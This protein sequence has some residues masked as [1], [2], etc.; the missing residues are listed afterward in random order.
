MNIK[1]MVLVGLLLVTGL[2]LLE[3]NEVFAGIVNSPHDIILWL[4]SNTLEKAG[5]CAYCHVPHSAKGERLFPDQTAPEKAEFGAVAALC[6]KCHRNVDY[7]GLPA[8]VVNSQIFLTLNPATRGSTVS[9]STMDSHPT[10]GTDTTQPKTLQNTNLAN[11]RAMDWPWTATWSSYDGIAPKA[12]TVKDIECSTCHNPHNW[13][14]NA[15]DT[16]SCGPAQ[17]KFLRAPVYNK[18][19]P[20]GQKN[21]CSICHPG[22]ESDSSSNSLGTHPVSAGPAGSALYAS[23]SEW[24][25]VYSS[26]LYKDVTRM[27]KPFRDS[28][29]V[30]TGGATREG[31]AI[32]DSAVVQGYLG[33]RLYDAGDGKGPDKIIC[34][35][36]HAPHGAAH[37]DDDVYGP[38]ANHGNDTTKLR[39]GPLLVVNN[40]TNWTR[41]HP[42]YDPLANATGVG[43][44][45]NYPAI[46]ETAFSIPAG[47]GKQNFLCEWCHG[48]TPNLQSNAEGTN[49]FAHPVN[50]YPTSTRDNMPSD[51]TDFSTMAIRYPPRSWLKYRESNGIRAAGSNGDL[52]PGTR[53][54]NANYLVCLSCHEPHQALANS[55][56]LKFGSETSGV[57]G[58]EGDTTFCDGCHDRAAVGVG[59]ASDTYFS[60]WTTHPSGP[61]AKLKTSDGGSEKLPNRRGLKT[62]QGATADDE[63]I[64][65]W[66]CHKAHKGVEKPLLA[67]YQWPFSQICVNCHCEGGPVTESQSLAGAWTYGTAGVAGATNANPSRYYKEG[68]V[69]GTWW[70]T[71]AGKRTGNPPSGE[72][73]VGDI[74]RRGSHY[75]GQFSTN[76]P[77]ALTAAFGWLGERDSFRKGTSGVKMLNLDHRPGTS[78]AGMDSSDRW[79]DTAFITKATWSGSNQKAHVGYYTATVSTKEIII[80]QTCHTAHRSAVGVADN[81]AISRLLLA[82]NNDSYMCK[83]CHIP[84]ADS[85]KSHPMHRDLTGSLYDTFASGTGFLY[86]TCVTR[87]M[88]TVNITS[89]KFAYVT[90]IAPANY[91]ENRMNCDAC[92][93]AHNADSKM[94]AMILEG[95]GVIA[96][97]ST[98]GVASPYFN[99][100]PVLLERND[101][102]TC[103]LCHA[104]GK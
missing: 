82:P 59:P 34:Q 44:P 84:E 89:D 14:G 60:T 45:G 73:A 61:T 63:Y 39:V 66:T 31:K 87:T 26:A 2:G 15:Y 10:K 38:L 49:A 1:R 99:K 54:A 65:C 35:S 67:D 30:S 42:N 9:D 43:T 5:V 41:S 32:W 101:K 74:T 58:T 40:A 97:G 16:S 12:T 94:G 81:P 104:Q 85:T 29:S 3:E 103:D 68:A 98:V 24:K 90:V 79:L 93:T 51:S 8:A 22:R 17:R 33:G 55:P 57:A 20:V 95:D 100:V 50:M 72:F 23:F 80:C 91:P 52:A 37:S 47:G 4:N 28:A 6:A 92:H 53:T 64:E 102:R 62:F 96:G 48:M 46:A 56:I 21:F 83:R 27:L 36:C 77:V 69:G 88:D 75:I 70:S 86:N 71:E 18:Y 11:A 76:R 13:N 19:G 25:D 7:L 78:V